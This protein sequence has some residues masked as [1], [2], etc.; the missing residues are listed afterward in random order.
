MSTFICRHMSKQSRAMKVCTAN[1]ASTASLR[2]G[3]FQMTNCCLRG[4]CGDDTNRWRMLIRLLL[5]GSHIASLLA[6]QQAAAD[7]NSQAYIPCYPIQRRREEYVP[8]CTREQPL[9][10]G[11]S[12]PCF[13]PTGHLELY[14]ITVISVN[15][16]ISLFLSGLT[17]W[18]ESEIAL[19]TFYNL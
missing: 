10:K 7:R 9:W 1:S 5:G 17:G 12:C 11:S 19:V 3:Q 2:T 13:G 6:K 14:R 15:S 18:E 8:W 4:W 16:K